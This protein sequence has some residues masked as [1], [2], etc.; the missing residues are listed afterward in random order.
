M[1]RLLV[2]VV[3]LALQAACVRATAHTA[4]INADVTFHMPK[5]SPAT[6]AV[7]QAL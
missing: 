6:R 7:R 3:G 1:V 2:L 5:D 4:T